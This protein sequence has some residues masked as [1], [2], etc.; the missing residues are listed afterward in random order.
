MDPQRGRPVG[1]ACY[2]SIFNYPALTR[3]DMGAI[4]W[5][6]DGARP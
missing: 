1:K 6:V 2:S 5:L 3:A 4:G